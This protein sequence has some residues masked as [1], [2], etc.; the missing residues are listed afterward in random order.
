MKQ[1]FI[2]MVYFISSIYAHQSLASETVGNCYGK[3]GMFKISEKGTKTYGSFY[4]KA[5]P[6]AV[7]QPILFNCALAQDVTAPKGSKMWVP[8]LRCLQKPG[9]LVFP[10]NA[11]HSAIFYVSLT[12]QEYVGVVWQQ[13][14]GL[15]RSIATVKCRFNHR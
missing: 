5:E 14:K 9:Q 12:T 1:F 7:V 11:Q 15:R 6:N 4:V 3:T 8:G 10:R 2:V 13:I